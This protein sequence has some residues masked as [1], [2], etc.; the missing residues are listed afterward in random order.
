GVAEWGSLDLSAHLDVHGPVPEP[1]P[2]RRGQA[3]EL[4][5]EVERAGLRGRGGAGFPTALKMHAVIGARRRPGGR[6]VVINAVEGEP[7]SVKDR[8]LV[9]SVPHLVLDGAALAARAV[10]AGEVV[11]CVSERAVE[12]ADAALRACSERRAL[13]ERVSLRVVAVPDGYVGGQESALVHF[14]NGGPAKPTFTPPMIFE[15]GV[16]GRPTLLSNAETFAHVA[17]IARHGAGWFRELGTP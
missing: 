5:A 10:S 6:T 1:R 8:T 4:I 17:L 11:L 15:Q 13:R 2:A 3:G 16:H 7:A 9:E 14:L 12:T